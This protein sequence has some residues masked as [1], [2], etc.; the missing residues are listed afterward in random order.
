MFK[1]KLYVVTSLAINGH[2]QQLGAY[3]SEE[4]ARYAASRLV[5]QELNH[6]ISLETIDVL[7]NPEPILGEFMHPKPDPAE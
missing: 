4:K 1:Y 6:Y 5:G 3:F 2:K 7:D